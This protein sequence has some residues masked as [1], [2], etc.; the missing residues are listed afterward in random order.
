MELVYILLLHTYKEKH[1]QIQNTVLQC[2]LVVLEG[3][4]TATKRNRKYPMQ[5]M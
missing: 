4:T 3:I 1:F 5:Y 2:I